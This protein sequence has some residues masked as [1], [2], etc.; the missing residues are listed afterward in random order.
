MKEN[1]Y[2]PSRNKISVH[3]KGLL[4][5]LSSRKCSHNKSLR[6]KSFLEVSIKSHLIP[7]PYFSWPPPPSPW[8][9][10]PNRVWE[11]DWFRPTRSLNNLV[12][13]QTIFTKL[14]FYLFCLH[15]LWYLHLHT[16]YKP[17]FYNPSK[18]INID[19]LKLQFINFTT[20]NP[21]YWLFRNNLDIGR[22]SS[23]YGGQISRNSIE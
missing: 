20:W 5:V 17:T 12:L 9:T 2:K 18:Y 16:A 21:R 4:S 8:R 22:T 23:V 3:P 13:K 1:V 10:K 11:A 6:S 7:V 19:F 15:L 14:V